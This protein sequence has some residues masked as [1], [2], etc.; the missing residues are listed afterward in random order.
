MLVQ[1]G[2]VI[3][4]KNIHRIRMINDFIRKKPNIHNNSAL[5]L[6]SYQKQKGGLR[7]GGLADFSA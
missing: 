5:G 4:F 2:S 3:N 6:S 7:K 1:K